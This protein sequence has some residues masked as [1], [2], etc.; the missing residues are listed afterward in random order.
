MV[1]LHYIVDK[2]WVKRVSKDGIAG[3]KGNDG[4]THQ[5]WWEAFSDW[6][7]QRLGG[8]EEDSLEAVGLV[9]RFVAPLEGRK[10]CWEGNQDMM[11]IG[12]GVQA[13]EKNEIPS[14]NGQI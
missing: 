7:T 6:E 11:A 9:R 10:H 5:W 12:S 4:V 2:P 3:Y 8:W 1:C 13:F 14:V